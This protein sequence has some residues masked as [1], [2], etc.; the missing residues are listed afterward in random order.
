VASA[1]FVKVALNGRVV[2]D[3]VEIAAPTGHAWTKKEV[4]TGPLF[5]QAD[6]GPVA[7]RNVRVRPWKKE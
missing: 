1:R 4:R 6:H 7:F 3:D 5:L 2:Q